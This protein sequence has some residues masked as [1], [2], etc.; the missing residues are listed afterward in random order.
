MDPQIFAD[1]L[2]SP[3]PHAG[4]PRDQWI[5]EPFIG[6]WA[7]EVRWYGPDKALI[8]EE[9]GEW[10]FARVLEGRGIQDVWVVPPRGQREVSAY[11]YGTSLRFHDPALGAWRSTW[12]GPMH[13]AVLTFTARR[14]GDAVVLET[15]PDVA[16]ARRWS[17]RD[18]TPS[19]F[20]WVHEALEGGEWR[21]VQSFAA[22]RT[23]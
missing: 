10:H 8:R 23:A 18:I 20:T 1:A 13:G 5:F 6:S 19:A 15:T 21:L 16:P 4:I 14:N 3:A 9:E 7:L 17:F 12:I 11:E 2:L 22:R